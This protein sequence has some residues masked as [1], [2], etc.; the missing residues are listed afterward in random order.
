[1]RKKVLLVEDDKEL[2]RLYAIRLKKGGFEVETAD[3]GLMAVA[4]ALS[5]MPDFI[6]LD[7]MLPKQ[8]GIQVL[9]ILKSNPMTKDIPV[10]V[11]TAYDHFKY[12][13][14][15]QVYIVEYVLKTETTP[16]K[17]VEKLDNYFAGVR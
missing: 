2:Q 17:I 11:L 10:M 3:D 9:Q 4:Q 6:I 1:M 16:Q 5:V 7:L 12:R 14:D 13:E 8:G 15:S